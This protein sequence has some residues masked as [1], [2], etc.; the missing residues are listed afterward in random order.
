[1]AQIV[2]IT[3]PLT[4]Q[5]AQVDQLEHTAQQIDDATARALEGGAID[6]L[7]AGK[8]PSISI[9]PISKGG[10]GADS[11]NGIRKNIGLRVDEMVPAGGS[12][13]ITLPNNSLFLMSCSDNIR[14][15]AVLFSTASSKIK[16]DT[17]L[18][19]LQSWSYSYAS[20]GLDL[21]LTETDRRFSAYIMIVTLG[22]Q[23]YLG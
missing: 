8:E 15:G 18:I 13:T 7:L 6:Q 10:T 1:M 11:V 9:L 3:N 4:G 2:T 16:S 21:P 20:R 14:E 17:V 12:T 22:S 19:P 5:P 23:V